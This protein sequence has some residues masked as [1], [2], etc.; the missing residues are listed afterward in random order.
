MHLNKQRLEYY[1]GN[2]DAFVRTRGELMENQEKR[3]IIFLGK[4]N[5]SKRIS[6]VQGVQLGDVII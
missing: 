3:Y 4:K 2:Y 1:G 5:A 6:Y